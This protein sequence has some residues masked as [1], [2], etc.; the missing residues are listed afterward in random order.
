MTLVNEREI[1]LKCQTVFKIIQPLSLS[2]PHL[3]VTNIYTP[4][5]QAFLITQPWAPLTGKMNSTVALQFFTN[6]WYV[7]GGDGWKPCLNSLLWH[8]SCATPEPS[9]PVTL[10]LRLWMGD[11]K[12]FTIGCL[13]Q[14]EN[15]IMQGALSITAI[16]QSMKSPASWHEISQSCC[17]P[18]HI[19]QWCHN[20]H[21]SC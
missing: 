17:F 5:W 13:C 16:W 9:P 8:V 11:S 4:N 12:D 20:E 2:L 1:Q 7:W 18:P 3:N 15:L 10:K 19:N 14:D 21:T 6:H